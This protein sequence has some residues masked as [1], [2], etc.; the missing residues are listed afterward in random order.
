MAVQA[1]ALPSTARILGFGCDSQV[2]STAETIPKTILTLETALREGTGRTGISIAAR[3]KDPEAD[4]PRWRLIGPE[5][6]ET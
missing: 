3:A 6:H 5:Y 4:A 1:S 2:H